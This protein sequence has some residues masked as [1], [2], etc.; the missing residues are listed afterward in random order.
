MTVVHQLAWRSAGMSRK[1]PRRKI[2]EDAFLDAGERGLWAVADGIGGHDSGDLA[3]DGICRELAGVE[4]NS[5]INECIARIEASL[6]LLNT[7]LRNEARSRGPGVLIGSTFSGVLIRGQHAVC[8]WSGDSRTYLCRGDALFQLTRD[9]KLVEEMV[10]SGE[11]CA[12]DAIHHPHRHI[13]TRAIGAEDSVHIDLN[14]VTLTIGDRLL[15]CTDGLSDCLDPETIA[16]IMQDDPLKTVAR[17]LDE[18]DARGRK[19]DAT[20]IAITIVGEA[21]MDERAKTP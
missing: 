20:A 10:Y 7:N 18:G 2:N 1:G 17:L 12:A 5:T 16:D 6:R 19:D 9:H 14:H 4:L 8:L 15:L 11:I 21:G 3:S 13:I